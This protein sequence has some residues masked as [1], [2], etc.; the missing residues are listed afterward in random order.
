MR[1]GPKMGIHHEIKNGTPQRHILACLAYFAEGGDDPSDGKEIIMFMDKS[2]LGAWKLAD[3]HVADSAVALGAMSMMVQAKAAMS[4]KE[5]RPQGGWGWGA[6]T[7]P[8]LAR[9]WT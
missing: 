7:G 5:T 3:T 8:R 6:R 9:V 1:I 4:H 2:V